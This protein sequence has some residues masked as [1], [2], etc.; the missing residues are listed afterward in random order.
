MQTQLQLFFDNIDTLYIKEPIYDDL[1]KSWYEPLQSAMA[2]FIGCVLN[3]GQNRDF[4]AD[5]AHIIFE[6]YNGLEEY[7]NTHYPS[8]NKELIEQGVQKILDEIPDFEDFKVMFEKILLT[9]GNELTESDL[10]YIEQISGDNAIVRASVTSSLAIGNFN[11]LAR[12]PFVAMNTPTTLVSV[13]CNTKPTL[14]L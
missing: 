13:N 1:Y 12:Y 2:E 8:S 9:I 3:I 5:E 10:D 7:L 11:I 14:G 6:T 4:T